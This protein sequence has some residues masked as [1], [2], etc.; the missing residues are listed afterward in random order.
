M[1]KKRRKWVWVFVGLVAVSFLFGAFL[2]FKEHP[3][4]KRAAKGLPLAKSRAEKTFGAVTWEEYRKETGR[5]RNVDLSMWKKAADSVPQQ[6]KDYFRSVNPTAT[7]HD[8]Y[9][10]D[11]EWFE[12]VDTLITNLHFEHQ[13]DE[14]GIGWNTDHFTDAKNLAKALMVGLVGAADEGD[15][16]AVLTIGTAANALNRALLEE[17]AVMPV[18][19][20]S[21][22][23][24]ITRGAV[25]RA[26]VRN[27]A[28]DAVVKSL[29]AL[30]DDMPSWLPI[31]DVMA[32]NAR[33]ESI[34]I[35]R[36]RSLNPGEID[37]SLD[38]WVGMGFQS[39]SYSPAV[40]K[41][42]EVWEEWTGNEFKRRRRTGTNTA[43]ALEA[44]YWEVTVD[45]TP[46]MEDVVRN[47]PGS[48]NM[49]R[50]YSAEIETQ[51]DRSYELAASGVLAL[52][53][54]DAYLWNRFND[55]A[56]KVAVEL[57][58]R[59][60]SHD[61]LPT[62][63]PADLHFADPFGGDPILFK[64]TKRGFLI[65]TRSSNLNDDGFPWDN[66]E[67]EGYEARA[68]MSRDSLDRGLVVSYDPIEFQN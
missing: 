4:Y 16:E 49:L 57:I 25:V 55:K 12:R 35:D 14:D 23:A 45:V 39:G 64:K 32:A 26:A 33:A 56:T 43:A 52:L 46:L 15:A 17:P 22:I 67:Q 21:A 58:D 50:R 62:V 38:Q 48:R 47:E 68:T 54:V 10:Q 7:Y 53:F 42:I 8:V 18:L 6:I 40:E 44:R 60:P 11:R 19:V 63:L 24:A 5:V 61:R 37:E 30:A 20:A 66:P 34:Y 29:V 13:P 2:A 36:L 41:G 31:R 1:K 65:Y 3:D 27:R 51:D 59:F 28:N 9:S